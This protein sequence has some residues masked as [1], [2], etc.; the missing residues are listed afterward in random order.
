MTLLTLLLFTTSL[1]MIDSACSHVKGKGKFGKHLLPLF[2]LD[3]TYININHGSYGSPPREV[4]EVYHKLQEQMDFSPEKWIRK[5]I[6]SRSIKSREL[7]ANYINADADNLVLIENASDAVNLVMKSLLTKTGE[8]VLLF[9]FAYNMVVKTVEYL[10]DY[11]GI[12]IIT[13]TLDK[14]DINSDE[15]ILKKIETVIRENPDIKLASIDHIPSS[16]SFIVPV[17]EI[18]ALLKQFGIISV[19]DGAHAVGQIPL[20]IKDIDPDIYLSNFHKWMF[21]PKSC[22]FLFV[23]K[24]MQRDIHPNIISYTYGSG[25]V[26]EFSF[27]GTKDYSA[28]FTIETA[29]GFRE[30]FGDLEIMNHNMELAFEAG[31]RVAELWGTEMLINDKERTGCMVNVRIPCDNEQALLQAVELTLERYNTWVVV[32]KFNDGKYYTRLSA[33]IYNE[34]EDY[35]FAIK[36]FTKVLEEVENRKG[37]SFP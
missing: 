13:L 32:Y 28:Y 29:L 33:Q 25:F 22:S 14:D 36:S 6:Y 17:K 3:P 5:E 2:Y 1:M 4:G 12:E 31:K 27:T 23:R 34:V 20:D 11:R 24:D 21:V 7:I 30:K 35:I 26:K 9:D 10:R 19:I 8:K 37:S 16:P 15:R 18:C